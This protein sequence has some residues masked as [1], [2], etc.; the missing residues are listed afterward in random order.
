MLFSGGND[1][2]LAGR[3][4][5]FAFSSIDSPSVVCSKSMRRVSVGSEF[6][7]HLGRFCTKNVL[8]HP[9]NRLNKMRRI[10]K[11][12]AERLRG[13]LFAPILLSVLLLAGLASACGDVDLG[14]DEETSGTDSGTSGGE[15][16]G[17]GEAQGDTISVSALLAGGA[18]EGADVWVS[19]YIVG[20]VAGTSL[21]AARFQ[22]PEDGVQNTN[23]LIADT[24]EETS[25]D[26][27]A[28][29]QLP[30]SSELRE[31]LC[32]S[33]YPELLGTRLAFYGTAKTYF[34]QPGISPLQAYGEVRE[35]EDGVA[36]PSLSDAPAEVFEGD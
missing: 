35:R 11:G 6:F 27:C 29:V 33:S 30:A 19:G 8:P 4:T 16:T 3:R 14:A 36:L 1:C 7:L 5:F 28:A 20:Y 17:G 12:A 32:L 2:L 18:E 23:L 10:Y 25:T 15:D 21:S 13:L 31:E 24:P 34:K 26:A 9:P 22:V